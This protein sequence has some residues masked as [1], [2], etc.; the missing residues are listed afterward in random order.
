M[1]ECDE[2]GI[3]FVFFDRTLP[4]LIPTSGVSVH[5]AEVCGATTLYKVLKTHSH[6][7]QRFELAY[8]YMADGMPQRIMDELARLP[9][10]QAFVFYNLTAH[11]ED[12]TKWCTVKVPHSCLLAE[13]L[14]EAWTTVRTDK[15]EGDE[16]NKAMKWTMYRPM[17]HP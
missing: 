1:D 5:R 7:L 3:F 17:G 15:L 10:L 2:N 11:H 6:S 16:G 4:L 8:V 13:R 9:R 12:D 14:S